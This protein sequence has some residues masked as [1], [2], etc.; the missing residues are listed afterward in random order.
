[1]CANETIAA[2][3]TDLIRR[4]IESGE[5]NEFF[6]PE[7]DDDKEKLDAAG[8]LAE[9]LYGRLETSETS[10]EKEEEVLD[11]LGT[12]L[13][14]LDNG[15]PWW[16]ISSVRLGLKPAEPNRELIQR[17]RP[18]L[19]QFLP[20]LTQSP[21]YPCQLEFAKCFLPQFLPDGCKTLF[22]S[23]DCQRLRPPVIRKGV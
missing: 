14:V 23:P 19:H 12:P 11:A 17:R 1:M 7:T 9:E 10:V 13:R 4:L 6:E 21:I 20:A 15:N 16:D 2:H 8:R 22:S 5:R 3:E 18:S